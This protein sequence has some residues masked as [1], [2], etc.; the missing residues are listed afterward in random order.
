MLRVFGGD[1]LIAEEMRGHGG[2]GV[3]EDAGA[4][5]EVLLKLEVEDSGGREAVVEEGEVGESEVVD[6]EAVGVGG[7]EGED[8]F[9]DGDVEAI[10]RVCWCEGE[11]SE[12]V[13]CEREGCDDEPTEARRGRSHRWVS[14]ECRTDR[15]ADW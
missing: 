11:L 2:A 5:G 9:V 15:D 14:F 10:G 8:D 13:G 4:D 1:G 12:G 7:V 3:D 6:G